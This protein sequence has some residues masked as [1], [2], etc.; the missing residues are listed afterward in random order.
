M[1]AVNVL[2]AWLKERDGDIYTSDKEYLDEIQYL[3]DNYGRGYIE[4]AAFY[5]DMNYFNYIERYQGMYSSFDAFVSH[6]I[7]L[8]VPENLK[9]CID[10]EK[11]FS[12]LSSQY[13]FVNGYIFEKHLTEK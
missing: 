9:D 4:C 8:I 2:A 6:W 10:T 7:S 1:D 11:C 13:D 12:K 3:L 5:K